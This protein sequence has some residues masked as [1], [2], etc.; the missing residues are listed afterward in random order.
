MQTI[1]NSFST[2]CDGEGF[3]LLIVAHVQHSLEELLAS[4]P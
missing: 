1:G 2:V 3:S 4:K